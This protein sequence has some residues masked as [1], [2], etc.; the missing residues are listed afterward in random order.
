AKDVDLDHYA[1]ITHGFVGADL[2]AF[3]KEAAMSALRRILPEINLEEKVIPPEVLEK[4]QVTKEDFDNAL[5]MVEPSAMR[6]VLIEV[7]NVK[8]DDIGGLERAKQELK[9]AVE[10]P[11]KYPDSFRKV[12]IEPPR[13]I[14]LYGPPGTGKTMLAKAVATESEANFISIKGPALLSKWVG[15]SLPFDEEILIIQD[16]MLQRVKIGDLV[17]K[18]EKEEVLAPTVTSEYR[19]KHSKVVDFIRHPAPPYVDVLVTETGREVRVTGGHSVFVKGANGLQEIIADQVIPNETRIA[20]PGY[21]QPPET[22]KELDVLGGLQGKN[23]ALYVNNGQPYVMQAIKKLGAAKVAEIIGKE[24]KNVHAYAKR[25]AMQ[26]DAFLLLMN[27]ANI[28]YD[29]RAL[30]ITSRY[31]RHRLPAVLQLDEDLAMFLGLWVAEGSYMRYGVRISTSEREVKRVAELCRRLFGNI[32]IYK[33]PRSMGRDVIILSLPLKAFMQHVLGLA[34]GAD[35]KSIP[36]VILSARKSAVAAFLRGYIS[37]D[38]NF[39][40][41]SLEISS[42]SRKVAND[43]MLLLSYFGIVARCHTKKEWTGSTSYRVRFSWSGFLKTFVEEIGFMDQ[44]R[45]EAVRNYISNLKLRRKLQ[46]PTQ[47]MDGDIYWDLVVAKKRKAYN[48]PFVYDISVNPTERFIAG[49]GGVVVHNSE[50]GVRETF[51]KAKMA[52][53]C[54]IFFDEI[55]SLVPRRGSG[56]GDSHVTERVI[57]QLL[58]EMDGL[59]KLEN[60]V[61]IGATNRPDLV[62]PALLRPGRFDR[63]VY[64][65]PPDERARL[66]IL[67]IHTKNM[68][69]AK[70]VDLKG[71]AKE[72]EGYSG[73]DLAALCREA[74]M[75]VLRENIKGGEVTMRHFRAAMQEVKPSLTPEVVKTYETFAE[76]KEKQAVRNATGMHY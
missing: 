65:P 41:K 38:G 17:D 35:K 48:H 60:V 64:V 53:P 49:F 67:K 31:R 57:S 75:R 61:V 55:D 44:E 6:E 26:I 21:I 52:A 46:S 30:E 34:D 62:D 74:A 33:K 14:L 3:C 45:T 76:R 16:G 66:E 28:T 5:K 25:A 68:P 19:A 15:E 70:D 8:W 11:L 22:V 23:L 1:D 43:I 7:P 71:L 51:R 9:E 27:A 24:P 50:R 13:G 72:T 37:G 42:T 10:W 73:S 40:G 47:H 56:F 29:S 32:L 18:Q 39:N 20:V 4:L 63:L 36:Q 12:G 54:I 69:L 58:T 2:E 59:E